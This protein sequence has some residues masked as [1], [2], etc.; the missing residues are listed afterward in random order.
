MQRWFFI[1]LVWSSLPSYGAELSF[2]ELHEVQRITS[3]LQVIKEV[4]PGET[5]EQVLERAAKLPPIQGEDLYNFGITTDA[6]WLHGT[7]TYTGATDLESYLVAED[8]KTDFIDLYIYQNKNLLRARHTGDHRV[9]ASRDY[10][11][12]TYAFPLNFKPGDA[13]E[14]LARMQTTG[15]MEIDWRLYP[16]AVFERQSAQIKQMES[17][18]FG[19]MASIILFNFLLFFSSRERIYL[20]YCLF[21]SFSCIS[22]AIAIG[23]GYAILWPESPDLNTVMLIVIP[24]FTPALALI[25][26]IHYL[27]LMEKLPHATRVMQGTAIAL[28]FLGIS[29]FFSDGFYVVDSLYKLLVLTCILIVGVSSYLAWKGDRAARLF[30]G[31]WL[32]LC[33]GASVF[34]L[35]RMGVQLT[36]LPQGTELAFGSVWEAVAL[37]LCLGDK[38]MQLRKQEI[39]Y[40]KRIQAEELQSHQARLNAEAQKREKQISEREALANRNLVRVICHDLANSQSII[41]N[42]SQLL[43]EMKM[44]KAQTELALSKILSAS[45]HQQEIITHV[46]DFEALNSSKQ[47]IKLQ[48]FPIGKAIEAAKDLL[49]AR[50]A[51]R[52]MQFSIE[53]SIDDVN[54][55]VEQRSFIYQVLANLMSNAIKFSPDGSVIQCVVTRQADEVEVSIIDKGIGMDAELMSHIFEFSQP[56]TRL[57]LGGEKGTGFGLPIVKSYIERYGGRLKVESRTIDAHPDDHGTR[58][59]LTLKYAEAANQQAA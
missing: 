28:F 52:K 10:D 43:V 18:Y 34:A 56:T 39:I 23:N 25:F 45:L 17:I 55:L 50:F 57:G 38:F 26:M 13:F 15:P 20:L 22:L 29:G 49:Q 40:L 33:I 1:F 36:S 11:H 32:P 3:S 24:A 16:R 9:Y 41:V 19:A 14:I 6:Y 47:E 42:Y 30:L 51:Q 8:L 54:V 21:Q 48:P 58:F 4:S 31:A 12:M 46:R 7:I 27:G 44:T 5:P 2:F 59:I 35:G 53:G 37:S